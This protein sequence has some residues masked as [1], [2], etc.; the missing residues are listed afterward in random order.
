[1]A[2]ATNPAS[3]AMVRNRSAPNLEV[4]VSRL[5]LQGNQRLDLA[6]EPQPTLEFLNRL[7]Q[8]GY[9]EYPHDLCPRFLGESCERLDRRPGPHHVVDHKNVLSLLDRVLREVE[10][11][12]G[13]RRIDDLLRDELLR[14]RGAG[15]DVPSDVPAEDGSREPE[16]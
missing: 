1:M 8:R 2:F 6:G 9:H 14:P 11:L 15:K 7:V 16:N 13:G 3:I 5:L 4:V 10:V 12:H